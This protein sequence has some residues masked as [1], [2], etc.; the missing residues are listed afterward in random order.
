MELYLKVGKIRKETNFIYQAA[1][2]SR[3]T[4]S[5]QCGRIPYGEVSKYLCT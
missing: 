1:K 2:T 3:A 5:D 4:I